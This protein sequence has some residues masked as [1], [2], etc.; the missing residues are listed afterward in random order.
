M[1]MYFEYLS[2]FITVSMLLILV[3]SITPFMSMYGSAM[4]ASSTRPS[5]VENKYR[6]VLSTDAVYKIFG[7]GYSP[8]ELASVGNM[9]MKLRGLADSLRNMGKEVSVFNVFYEI[10]GHKYDPDWLHNTTLEEIVTAPSNGVLVTSGH[11]NPYGILVYRCRNSLFAY[12]WLPI[13]WDWAK[14]VEVSISALEVGNIIRN[15]PVWDIPSLVIIIG[16]NSGGYGSPAYSGSS[17]LWA[18]RF[19]DSDYPYYWYG[20]G[21]IGFL[22]P[23]YL[24]NTGESDSY[25]FIHEVLRLAIEQNYD[26]GEAVGQAVNMLKYSVYMDYI[27]DWSGHSKNITY[28]NDERALFV[29]GYYTSVDPSIEDEVVLASLEY[30]KTHLPQLYNIVMNNDVKPI[31]EKDIVF[32]DLNYTGYIVEWS[33]R[34][35]VDIEV[36][37][38]TNGY[39]SFVTGVYVRLSKD[40]ISVSEARRLAYYSNVTIEKLINRMKSIGLTISPNNGLIMYKNT[41]LVLLRTNGIWFM[42]L[43]S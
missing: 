4:L 43:Y 27:T 23:I 40:M 16:C 15:K 9:R 36:R 28:G 3:L 26:L 37:V 31:T 21:F 12:N 20:R 29:E 35:R 8:G 19:D 1:V 39:E 22:I 32:V 41:P 6:F 42:Q 25:R 10:W 13:P 17:W 33:V 11:S 34:G 24:P 38:L 5:H 7:P 30:L 2:V 14:N 18:F